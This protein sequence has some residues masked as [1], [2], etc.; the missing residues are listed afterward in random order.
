MH[1]REKVMTPAK[2]V[3]ELLER[4]EVIVAPGVYDALSAKLAESV[5]FQALI[6]TGQALRSSWPR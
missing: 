6:T 5:G 3:R 1:G 4:S 2:R